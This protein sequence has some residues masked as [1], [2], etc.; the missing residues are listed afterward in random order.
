[1][2]T[3]VSGEIIAVWPKAVVTMT[4]AFRWST[5]ADAGNPS[6][7]PKR[8]EAQYW[9]ANVSGSER[10]VLTPAGSVAARL[11]ADGSGVSN[12]VLAGDWTS[13]GIDGGCVEAAMT[14]GMQAARHLTGSERELTGELPWL[15]RSDPGPV[16]MPPALGPSGRAVEDPVEEDA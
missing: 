9:R 4:D 11:P 5:L 6:E 2:R 1:M 12:L 14:S 15:G 16:S 7:G 13:N 8:L 3:F 10:Y